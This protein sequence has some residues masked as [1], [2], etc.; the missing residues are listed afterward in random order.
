MNGITNL[1]PCRHPG[2][3]RDTRQAATSA[4]LPLFD[5]DFAVGTKFAATLSIVPAFAGMTA[6]GMLVAENRGATS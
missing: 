2:E 3:G 6:V 4:L 1:T 5:F